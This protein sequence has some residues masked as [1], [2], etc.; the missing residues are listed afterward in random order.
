MLR[1]VITPAD[2]GGDALDELKGWLAISRP[3]EDGLLIDLLGASLALCEAFT[4]R[5]PLEQ[6]VEEIIPSRRGD[7]VLQSQPAL[8]L[9][10]LETVSEDGER[11]SL[12]PDAVGFT[13]D[14]S[15]K[16]RITLPTDLEGARIVV[17]LRAGIAADW[18]SLP[19]ALK[20]GMIRLAAFH[21]RDRETGRDSTPPASVAALWRPWRIARLA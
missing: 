6:T 12:E 17:T 16:A 14:A 2:L 4:G 15:G 10:S 9:Q 21:Y 1:T 19:H 13:I 11:A 20:H 8:S 5:T 3:D 18:S 7:F